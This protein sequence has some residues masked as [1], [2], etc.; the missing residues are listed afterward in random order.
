MN[1]E[2][3]QQIRIPLISEAC[4]WYDDQGALSEDTLVDITNLGM[5]IKSDR[6][7]KPRERVIIKFYLPGDLGNLNL[8]AEVVWKRWMLTKNSKLS[9]GFA[10]K[11][12]DNREDH[13]KILDA[14]CVYLRNKQIITVTKRLVEE[15]FK[16]PKPLPDGAR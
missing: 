13:L 11:F 16:N 14:Y 7:P 4:H 5:F 3:R 8:Y 15:F 12:V 2:R 9:K 10:V 6:E 1:K